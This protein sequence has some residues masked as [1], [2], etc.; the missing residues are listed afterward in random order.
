MYLKLTDAKPLVCYVD[1]G[2]ASSVCLV[3]ASIVDDVDEE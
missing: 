3:L 2:N 1:L